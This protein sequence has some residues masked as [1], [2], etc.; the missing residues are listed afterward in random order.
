MIK[1]PKWPRIS[2]SGMKTSRTRLMTAKAKAELDSINAA[3][4][5]EI[6]DLRESGEPIPARDSKEFKDFDRE[7]TNLSLKYKLQ[8]FKDA[9][10]IYKQI[11]KDEPPKKEEPKKD[12]PAKENKEVIRRWGQRR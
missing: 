1:P 4:D 8:S 3:L 11:K 12:D 2:T 7:L 10:D 5:K 6:D 9:Y